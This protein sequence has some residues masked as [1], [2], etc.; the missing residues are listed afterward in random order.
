MNLKYY[1]KLLRR[2]QRSK[3]EIYY[4]ILSAIEKDTEGGEAKKTRV[5]QLCNMSYD[6]MSKHLIE[7]KRK[8]LI[9]NPILKIT[10]KGKKFLQDYSKIE[11]FTKKM[12]IDFL[13]DKMES[14]Q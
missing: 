1:E 4:D 13:K 9:Q 5:Q 6:K 7:L 8:N 12:E 2:P 14:K 10:K 3:L 11:N